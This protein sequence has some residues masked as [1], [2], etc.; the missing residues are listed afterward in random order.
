MMASQQF[1]IRFLLYLCAAA[2][3]RTSDLTADFKQ[4]YISTR[5]ISGDAQS[6]EKLT[7]FD[8]MTACSIDADKC[9][10]LHLAPD[11]NC[12]L[13]SELKSSKEQRPMVTLTFWIKEG[14]PEIKCK[15]PAF[16]LSHGNSRYH[17]NKTNKRTWNDAAA[18]CEGLGGK[19]VQISTQAEHEFLWNLIN[20]PIKN[21]LGKYV[22]IGA[23]K[24]QQDGL[25]HNQGWKWQGSDEPFNASLWYATQ[26][27]NEN[28][29]E[30]GSGF[31]EESSLIF[32]ASVSHSAEAFICECSPL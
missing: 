5:W 7:L 15:A 11:D 21:G 17:F 12:D 8:C 6:L 3:Y 22:F 28:R 23:Y 24:E 29:D 14:A 2:T 9:Y 25:P 27:R 18:F 31:Y 1:H 30:F 16:P 20:K 26:P 19:L 13:I 32:D 4:Q 10:A